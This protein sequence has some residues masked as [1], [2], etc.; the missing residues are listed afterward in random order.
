MAD[1]AASAMAVPRAR[2]P[3]N[4]VCCAAPGRLLV[5]RSRA[6]IRSGRSGALQG[7]VALLLGG[8]LKTTLPR[9]MWDSI[10]LQTNP[11]LAAASVV[12]LLIVLIF[13]GAMELAQIRRGGKNGYIRW[14]HA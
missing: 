3:L 11:I 9:R 5:L 10:N 4:P 6:L 14:T 2:L 8:G 13:F 12:V 7:V 1:L